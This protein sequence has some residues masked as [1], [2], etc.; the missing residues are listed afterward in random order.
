VRFCDQ[1]TKRS[2]VASQIESLL[3]TIDQQPLFHFWRLFSK[4]S[5]LIAFAVASDY[6]CLSLK[7]GIVTVTIFTRLDPNFQTVFIK[8][9]TPESL[10]AVAGYCDQKYTLFASIYGGRARY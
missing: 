7:Y 1:I 5:T 9:Q 3:K 10:E 8:E 4:S 2:I 6:R